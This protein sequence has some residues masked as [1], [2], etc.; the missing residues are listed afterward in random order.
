MNMY[1]ISSFVM[2]D[3]H[4]N[5]DQGSCNRRSEIRKIVQFNFQ[6]SQLSR[7]SRFDT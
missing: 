3:T 7:N 4:S 5:D 6:Y 1:I 2:S